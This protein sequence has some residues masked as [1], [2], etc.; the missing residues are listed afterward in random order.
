MT[1]ITVWI[2][3]LNWLDLFSD[4]DKKAENGEV[5]E[6]VVDKGGD[7]WDEQKD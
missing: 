1:Q 4:E 2:V 7:V 6:N 5:F 3:W